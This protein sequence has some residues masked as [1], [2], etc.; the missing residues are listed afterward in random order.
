MKSLLEKD[1]MYLKLYKKIIFKLILNKT[2]LFNKFMANLKKF[3]NNLQIQIIINIRI[4]SLLI[5]MRILLYEK[6]LI[7]S[8]EIRF[9]MVGGTAVSSNEK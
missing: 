8:E 7:T 5:T 1:K 2:I 3:I 6:K 4:F 9:L